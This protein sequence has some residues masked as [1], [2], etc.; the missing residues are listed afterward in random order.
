MLPDSSF[1]PP[2]SRQGCRTPFLVWG[3]STYKLNIALSRLEK[4]LLPHQQLVGLGGKNAEESSSTGGQSPFT[5][6]LHFSIPDLKLTTYIFDLINLIKLCNWK[7]EIKIKDFQ[8]FR[9]AHSFTCTALM[10]GLPEC[11]PVVSLQPC[12]VPSQSVLARRRNSSGLHQLS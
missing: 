2:P 7:Q 10:R 5:P 12:S 4:K 1:L 11:Q 9:Y 6:P 3:E 8:N